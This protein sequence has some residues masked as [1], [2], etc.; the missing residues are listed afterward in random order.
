MARW[1]LRFPYAK[2]RQ[3]IITLLMIG[4]L[5]ISMGIAR[6]ISGQQAGQV[7]GLS[8]SVPV[9]WHRLEDIQS[10]MVFARQI[11][12]QPQDAV[13]QWVSVARFHD[14]G[15][16]DFTQ[17]YRLAVK[18]IQ[19]SHSI[20]LNRPRHT[21]PISHGGIQGTRLA[22]WGTDPQD[23]QSQK[24]VL[25]AILTDGQ[26]YWMVCQMQEV[27]MDAYGRLPAGSPIHTRVF[28]RVMESLALTTSTGP[29]PPSGQS[30][31]L[32]MPSPDEHQE[33][34]SDGK[35]PI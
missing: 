7:D 20:R 32:S 1:P 2:T 17:A 9:R 8:F 31:P 4:C 34:S 13:E 26:R 14:P 15:P 5:L 24:L 21:M 12:Y 23:P 35:P 19:S 28:D 6:A 11:N 16:A 33:P 25:L 22:M 29:L 3:W 27:L 30:P 18:A 10:P